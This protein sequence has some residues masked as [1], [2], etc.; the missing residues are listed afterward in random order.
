MQHRLAGRMIYPESLKYLPLYGLALCKSTPL[1]GGHADA[2]LDERCAVGSTLMTLPVK[3]L[4]K[5]LYPSLMRVD[6]FIV[7]VILSHF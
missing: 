4:V 7:K 1:R 5:F 2:Q 6:E 3:H